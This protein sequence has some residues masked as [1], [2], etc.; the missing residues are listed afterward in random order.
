MVKLTFNE[1]RGASLDLLNN[2]LKSQTEDNTL[3][4]KLHVVSNA[5]R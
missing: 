4:L 1:N 3:Q 2:F 5:S